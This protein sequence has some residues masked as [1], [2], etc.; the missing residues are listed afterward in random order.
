MVQ[1][2]TS[3]NILVLKDSSLVYIYWSKTW[4]FFIFFFT[5]WNYFLFWKIFWRKFV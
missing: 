5:F 3:K 1:I 4:H 2:W